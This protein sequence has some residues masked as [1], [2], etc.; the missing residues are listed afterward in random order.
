MR[1]AR[2]LPVAAAI[3]GGAALLLADD[4]G[5][6]DRG[7]E[8][9]ILEFQSMAPVPRPFTGA[10]N[11]VRGVAGGGFPWVIASAE[12]E[13]SGSGHLEV[14]VKGLVIDPADAAAMQAGVAG[15]NPV[16]NFRAIVSCLSKDAGSEASTVN[17]MTGLFPATTGPA[18]A[19]GGNA[20]IEALVD[21][22][23]VC[24]APIVFVTSPTGAWFAAT[25]KVIE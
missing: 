16:P 21:L 7:R 9:N 10:A 25:G 17:V 23:K 3:V 22:P 11:A 15:Q 19:G 4:S 24:I 12:G 1:I 20:H 8:R 14:Q 18:S 6:S 2:L 5:R 13:L